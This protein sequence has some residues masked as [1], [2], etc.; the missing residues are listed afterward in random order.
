MDRTISTNEQLHEAL[1][2]LNMSP[3][4][5]VKSEYEQRSPD[6][7]DTEPH[8]HSLPKGSTALYSSGNMLRNLSGLQTDGNN[9]L[10]ALNDNLVRTQNMLGDIFKALNKQTELLATIARNTADTGSMGGNGCST[11]SRTLFK[12]SQMTVKDYGFTNPKEVAAELLVSVIR[13]VEVAVRSRGIK[14]MSTSDL[15]RQAATSIIG[16]V[17]GRE[18]SRLEG[19]HG[20]IKLPENK[21]SAT[22][23]VASR[24]GTVNGI[25]PTLTADSLRELMHDSEC[26]TFMSAFEQIVERIRYVRVVLPF[27]EADMLNAMNYPYFDK[28]GSVICDWSRLSVRNQTATEI[29]AS[30]FKVREKE[31][32]I[33]LMARGA[34]ESIAVNTV[35]S[36]GQ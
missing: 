20:I 6:V 18:F 34:S 3:T 14:Y 22:L 11:P 1:R 7:H 30:K 32:V 35:V 33:A 5:E 24:I 8:V 9:K 29:V 31:T 21:S 19:N 26:R 13:L 4:L 27:Y 23:R 25:T 15:T 2:G 10:D 16:A 28:E 12:G 36:S 17:C